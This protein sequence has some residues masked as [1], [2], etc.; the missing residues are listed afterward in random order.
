MEPDQSAKRLHSLVGAALALLAGVGLVLLLEAALQLLQLGPSNRLFLEERRGPETRYTPNRE[1]AHR[2]F[3]HRF[4]RDFAS[5]AGF[6]EPKP[7]NTVRIFVLGASTVAGFP[8]PPNTAFPRF[9]GQMLTD[10]YPARRF[11]VINCGLTAINS[12]CLLDFVEE[13][14]CYSP[15]LIVIYAGH[16][17][18]VGPYGVTTPFAKF[19]NDRR[20]IRLYMYL[21]RSRIHYGLKELI[22]RLRSWGTGGAAREP[23]G[24]HLVAREI[25]PQDRGYETT[26][27]NFRRNLEEMLA[28]AEK[29]AVPVV[30]STLVSNLKDFHPL[31]SQCD[32]SGLSDRIE[33][34]ASEGSLEKAAAAA[35]LALENNPECADLHFQLGRV[36]Y[37][38]GHYPQ[39]AE[40]FTS[41]RDFDRM[42]FRAPASFNEVILDLTEESGGRVLLNDIEKA[43][44][45]ASPEGIAG[46][47]LITE[48]LHPTVYGH[49]LIARTLMGALAENP[50]SSAWGRRRE[51]GL[52][53]YERYA[54]RLGYSLRDQVFTRNYLIRFLTQLPYREPPASLRRHMASLV[55]EQ[56]LQIPRLDPAARRVFSERGEIA[57]LRSMVDSLLPEDRSALGRLLQ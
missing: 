33:G 49:F 40:A 48:Y 38:Q 46:N 56:V 14:A 37:L 42:R 23:F 27:R 2:F 15:D 29:Q 17:E 1:V 34:L 51:R 26:R 45:A 24:L 21:Q 36:R 16:N 30:L 53:D 8:N 7:A 4:R 47:E 18:F 41:A 9:L 54:R 19:G 13:V 28:L 20:G 11:E 57:F 22:F 43:F 31:R 35:D 39:A 50:V 32:G 3:P 6:T 25:G 12:F 55:R 52:A 10:V 5:G 44:A